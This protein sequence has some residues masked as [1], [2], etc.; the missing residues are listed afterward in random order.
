MNSTLTTD[1]T[2]NET[3]TG[4]TEQGRHPIGADE[5][6]DVPRWVQI[7]Q[8]GTWLGHPSGP[9]VVTREHLH[10]ALE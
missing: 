6:A 9:E 7:A 2:D 10:S 4:A 8:A 5:P 1:T 3:D